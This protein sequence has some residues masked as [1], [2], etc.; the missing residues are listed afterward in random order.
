MTTEAKKINIAVIGG[1][2]GGLC[3]AIGLLQHKHIHVE[4]YEAAHKFSEIGAG[5]AFGPNAQRALRLI[6][7][8]TE[9]V[10]FRSPSRFRT[11]SRYANA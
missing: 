9:K 3:V 7:P 11:W 10:R 5:V 2:I 6:G 1:G 8:E 4:V